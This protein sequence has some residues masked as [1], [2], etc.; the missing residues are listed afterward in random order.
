MPAAP[1]LRDLLWTGTW[2]A[3]IAAAHRLLF[4]LPADRLAPFLIQLLLI[5][6]VFSV[7]VLLAVNTMPRRPPRLPLR[8]QVVALLW[9]VS[10]VAGR[11]W[12]QVG[13]WVTNF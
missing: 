3:A 11:P 10:I 4:G 5:S 8:W 1:N 2:V 7:P 9:A 13:P 12:D 6:A